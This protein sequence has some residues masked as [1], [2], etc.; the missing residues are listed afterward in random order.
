MIETLLNRSLECLLEEATARSLARQCLAALQDEPVTIAIDDAHWLDEA[1]E[2][3]LIDMLTTPSQAAITVVVVHRSGQDPV[4]LISQARRAGVVHEHHTLQALDD[5][6]IREIAAELSREQQEETVSVAGGN[7]LFARVLLAAFRRHP[8][9]AQAQGAL[10]LAHGS[11]SSVLAAAVTED[12]EQLSEHPRTLLESL[13]VHGGPLDEAVLADVAEM[14]RVETEAGLEVLEYSGLYTADSDEPLHPVVR[15]GAY[16]LMSP[17]RRAHLH[18]TVAA[19]PNVDF[20]ERTEHLATLGDDLSA[21]E[22]DIIFH[23]AELAIGTDPKATVRWLEVVPV[24]YRSSTLEILLARAE[25]LCGFSERA[26]ERLVPLTELDPPDG[27]EARVLLA[28]ALRMEGQLP[29]ARAVLT[30]DV[31]VLDPLL[32]RE[33]IDMLALIDGEAPSALVSRLATYPGRE[34]RVTA[35]AYLTMELLGEGKVS[36]A[37]SAFRGVSQWMIQA[38]AGILRDTL[39]AVACAAWSAY[40]LD[41]FR[42]GIDL[43]ERGLRI[44]RRY[45]RVDVFANLSIAM[46]F[47]LLQ[48]GRLDE[49]DALVEEVIAEGDRYG[50]PGLIAMARAVLAI[51]AQGRRDTEL[52]E[53]RLRDLVAAELPEFG[54]WRRAVLTIRARV[55]AVLGRPEPYQLLGEPQDAMTALRYADAALISAATG[56]LD[57]ARSILAEGLALAEKQGARSQRAVLQTTLAEILL[58]T[59]DPVRAAELFASARQTFDQLGMSLQLGRVHAGLARVGVTRGRGSDARALLTKREREVSDLVSEGLTNQE[60]AARL[61]ISRRTVDE[62]VSNSLKK[63]GVSSRVGIV[64]A[65][66]SVG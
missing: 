21:T 65:L 28:N 45:G 25:V 37:R 54:W 55:S 52:L 64:Q 49:A 1:S 36:E 40:M 17:T 30:V 32:L 56:E 51:T 31:H 53:R 48:V 38:P 5:D 7:P 2:Q 33:L 44:A 18:R 6:A 16:Q 35:A 59:E 47:S 41:E 19:L 26:I 13:A 10:G 23:A 15:L 22:V 8:E 9:A 3:F 43:G 42:A 46:A 60:I 63:L 58:Q 50:T 14:T 57:T 34:N 61:V 20:V 11:Q 24:Q 27:I 12:V 29:E 62:H 66:S 4:S 39:H